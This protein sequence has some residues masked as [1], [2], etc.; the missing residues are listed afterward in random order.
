MSPSLT[1]VLGLDYSQPLSSTL[2]NEEVN[3]ANA[4]RATEWRVGFSFY[5][6]P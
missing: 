5:L 2:A 6:G 3:E 4:K 1:W